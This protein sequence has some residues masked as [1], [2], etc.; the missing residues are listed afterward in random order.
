M[1]KICFLGFRDYMKDLIHDLIMNDAKFI[2]CRLQEQAQ[3][4]NEKTEKFTTKWVESVS[5]KEGN[6]WHYIQ[7]RKLSKGKK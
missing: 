4:Y 3:I 5:H 2:G 1:I 7:Q 6:L